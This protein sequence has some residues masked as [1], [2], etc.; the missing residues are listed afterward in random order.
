MLPSSKSQLFFLSFLIVLIVGLLGF[1]LVMSRYGA[2]W[3]KKEPLGQ[4]P[5]SAQPTPASFQPP[6]FSPPVEKEHLGQVKITQLDLGQNDLGFSL[7]EGA[8]FYAGFE[9]IVEV[10][11][12]PPQ[13]IIALNSLDGKR[14]LHYL[15]S[16][17]A[18]VV[19]GSKVTEGEVLGRVSKEPLPTREINLIVSYFQNGEK[20]SLSQEI[21]EALE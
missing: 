18:L 6:L 21:I 5:P 10:V 2:F 3:Q 19:N 7:P 12:E 15:F 13:Q 16:G 17:V 8:P 4:V 11:G 9:G 1:N 14:R 20:V